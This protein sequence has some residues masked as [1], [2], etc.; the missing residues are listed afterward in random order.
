MKQPDPRMH[1]LVS[2]AKSGL[3]IIAGVCLMSGAIVSAGILLI[4]A[5]V[6]GVIE[7]IV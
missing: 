5:E 7:E 2:M 1:F 6:L 4:L 3:R